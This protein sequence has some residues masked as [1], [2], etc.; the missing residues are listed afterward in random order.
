MNPTWVKS[1]SLACCSHINDV[2][3]GFFSLSLLLLPK[4]S[5]L[6]LSL[7]LSL[8]LSL[9]H[10]IYLS[11][12]LSISIFPAAN[13]L[14]HNLRLLRFFFSFSS[15]KH[16][17]FLLAALNSIKSLIA[18]GFLFFPVPFKCSCCCWWCWC[19]CY[20]FEKFFS[21][22]QTI[23]TTSSLLQRQRRRPR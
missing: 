22:L 23:F 6:S 12:C 3:G 17:L 18:F 10:M 8:S 14:T 20:D 16:L 9:S 5:P 2:V 7:F 4:T 1:I 21:L 11:F 15:Q 13:Y 19:C